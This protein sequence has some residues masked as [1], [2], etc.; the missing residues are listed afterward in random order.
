MSNR[1][2]TILKGVAAAALATIFLAATIE[3]V[4]S[5]GGG[6]GGRGGHGGGNR[7]F[8][9]RP[10][11]GGNYT[12]PGGR[13]NV[14]NKLPGGNNKPSKPGKPGKPS[15]P[16]NNGNINV[17]CQKNCGNNYYDGW[18]RRDYYGYGVGLAAGIAIGSIAYSLPVG[19]VT[20]AYGGVAYRYCGTTWYQ[21]QYSGST[22][23]YIVVKQPY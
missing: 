9:S 12:R 1:T 15:K 21:P 8:Q 16:G 11:G 23:A 6:G 5:R 22:V 20:R 10:S 18:D 14:S 19:C 4:A 13:D 7:G 17:G 2:T 3:F